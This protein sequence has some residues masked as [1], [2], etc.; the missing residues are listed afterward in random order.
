MELSLSRIMLTSALLTGK[1]VKI[2]NSEES[3]RNCKTAMKGKKL[4]GSSV[5]EPSGDGKDTGKVR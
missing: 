3:I 4:D 5:R 1:R 2:V